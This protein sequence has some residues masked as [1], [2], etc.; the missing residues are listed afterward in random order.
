LSEARTRHQ[1][2]AT[3]RRIPAKKLAIRSQKE[4]ERIS[5]RTVSI[6]ENTLAIVPRGPVMPPRPG[7]RLELDWGEVVPT[8]IFPCPAR[9]RIWSA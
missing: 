3:S 5:F 9:E 2:P 1:I 6:V 7:I 4:G 8:V